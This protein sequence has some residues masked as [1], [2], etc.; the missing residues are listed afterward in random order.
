MYTHTHT[1]THTHTPLTNSE[2][3]ARR[4]TNG[5]VCKSMP[6]EP[7][8]ALARLDILLEQE[9]W[10]LISLN[11]NTWLPQKR[12]LNI[13]SSYDFCLVNLNTY[14]N[15]NSQHVLSLRFQTLCFNCVCLVLSNIQLFATLWTVALQAPL[16]MRIFQARIL[17]W[18]CHALL[19]GIFSTQRWNRGLPHCGKILYHLSH[20]R[21]PVSSKFSH[22]IQSET[23]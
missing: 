18:G 7:P 12:P 20:Q 3:P 17:E 11:L 14:Q 6:N 4:L 19:Q 15:N 21:T 8:P 13:V 1:H 10:A 22:S 2:L 23:P 5:S 9:C 16:S